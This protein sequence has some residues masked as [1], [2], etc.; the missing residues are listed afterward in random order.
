MALSIEFVTRADGYNAFSVPPE[1]PKNR[2]LMTFI[3]HMC[4]CTAD[5]KT[6]YTK[7]STYGVKFDSLCKVLQENVLG[8]R[9]L[10]VVGIK[11]K[12]TKNQHKQLKI[13]HKIDYSS[14][15]AAGGPSCSMA[16]QL[17]SLLSRFMRSLGTS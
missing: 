15:A 9:H 13:K 5:A 11:L 12:I 8:S 10:R 17:H 14:K 2:A 1:E 4:K 3:I 16:H 6:V 7:S